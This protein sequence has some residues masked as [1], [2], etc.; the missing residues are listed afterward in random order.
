[1]APFYASS[2]TGN[3]PPRA[4][5][6]SIS[7]Q[8]RPPQ[9]S[10]V[11]LLHRGLRRA[12]VVHGAVVRVVLGR[13]RTPHAAR[14]GAAPCPLVGLLDDRVDDLLHLLLL[15]VI[16][17]LIVRGVPLQPLQRLVYRCLQGR[18]VVLL[19]ALLQLVAQGSLH[20]VQVG[21]QLVAG[22]HGLAVPL[23]LLGVLLGLAHHALDLLVR[24]PAFLAG[25]GDLLRLARGLV[26]GAHLENTICVHVEGDLDLGHASRRGR[27]AHQLKLA[28]LP[29]VLRHRPLALEHL[30]EHPGLVVGEGGEP[31]AL[32]HGDGGAPLH[33]LGHHA[34]RSLDA[35][36][37]RG[38]VQ[39][40]HVLGGVG[41]GPREDAPLHRGAVGHGLVR[42]DL[43]VELL[44]PEVLGQ[45]RAHLGDARGAA[46]EDHF[47]HLP[48]RHARVL[49]HLGD[50]L[51][52]APEEV[53]VDLLELGPG[54][55][56]REVHALEECLNVHRGLGLRA[57]R[58]LGVLALLAQPLDRALVLGHVQPAL[59][60]EHRDEV[61][62]QAL[63]K[64][65]PAQVGVPG[66]RPHLEDAVVDGQ[67]RDVEGAPAQVEDQ[68]VLLL[69]LLVQAVGDGGGCGLVDHP[70][71]LQARDR[72]RVFRGLAL[73]VVEVGGHGDHRAPDLAAQEHLRRLL[74]LLQHHGADFLWREGL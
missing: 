37:Q 48:L 27:D 56:A 66:G 1:M 19:E 70:L 35:Q 74:H 57:Q 62:H 10:V 30:D 40:K 18:T 16:R 46:H 25:D 17:L 44:A 67:E 43:Q 53:G 14:V 55:R 5:R 47:V 41:G 26:L 65:L 31:L 63:V 4:A 64:V 34:A 20:I 33:Q 8:H 21:F 11:H 36:A 2:S 59:P 24:Q 52:C 22:L 50:G 68:H 3:F 38:H 12:L 42:V 73:G 13:R 45:Q 54:D 58:A 61:V 7:H 6:F 72:P 60:L 69:P 28:Q 71:H 39:Q 49:Q 15:L 9:A 51:Q 29:V 23:V 32:A